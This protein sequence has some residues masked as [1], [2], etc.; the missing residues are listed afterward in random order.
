[1]CVCGVLVVSEC[2][3][4]PKMGVLA[5]RGADPKSA[6]HTFDRSMLVVGIM[7]L[8]LPKKKL[9]QKRK[10]IVLVKTSKSKVAFEHADWGC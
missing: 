5:R 7:E 10:T 6:P 9:H 8:I 1:M 2:T 4:G 3:L